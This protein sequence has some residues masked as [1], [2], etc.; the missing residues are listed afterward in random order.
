MTIT[1]DLFILLFFGGTIAY[2]LFL[3]RSRILGIL[4]NLYVAF[5]VT[6]IAGDWI[7]GLLSN[8]SI[9]SSNL[10]TSQFGMKVLLLAVITAA[11]SLKSELSGLD[12]GASLS[13]IHTGIIGFL[14]A[15]FAL[16]SVFSFMSSAELSGVDSNFALL[17]ANYQVLWVLAPVVMLIGI[18]FFHK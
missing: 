2:S 10:A 3:G 1:W 11:L 9:V 17:I 7:Y 4:V 12:T 18:S 8:F 15:G 14:T 16:S 6:T 5:T 13:K